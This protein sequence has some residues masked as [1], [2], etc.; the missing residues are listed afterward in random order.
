MIRFLFTCVFYFQV[1]CG[2]G[3]LGTMFGCD[4][5]N[6]KPDLVTVAKVYKPLE[7]PKVNQFI[8][9]WKILINHQSYY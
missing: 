9:D 4:K 2:F 1:I 6:I 5:Y 3:R 7:I 8:S